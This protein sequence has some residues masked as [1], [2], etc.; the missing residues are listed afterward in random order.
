MI[1]TLEAQLPNDVTS[2][3]FQWS[4]DLPDS[5]EAPVRA[6]DKL[7]TLTVLLDGKPYGTVDLVAV[8]SVERSALLAAKQTLINVVHSWQFILGATLAIALI[9]FLVIL[10]RVRAMRR[11]R[12]GGR[13]S[14]THSSNY[15]GRR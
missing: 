4:T 6:G 8:N 13:R 1:G 15:R 7:G 12:Y 2:D 14:G 11:S 10:F 5:V 9:L 3:D